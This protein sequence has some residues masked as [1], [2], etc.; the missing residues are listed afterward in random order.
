MNPGHPRSSTFRRGQPSAAAALVAAFAVGCLAPVP[1]PGPANSPAAS[2]TAASAQLVAPTISPTATPIPGPAE[3]SAAFDG[4]DGPD[5]TLEPADPA[6][7]R[8]TVDAN[9]IRVTV[10]IERNPMRAG[11][12]TWVTTTLTNTGRDT[13][14]W[15]TDGCSIHVGV[16]GEMPMHWSAGFVQAGAEKTFKDWAF[17]SEIPGPEQPIWLN[18]TPEPF[19]GQGDFGCADVGILHSL[20]TGRRIRDRHQWDGDAAPNQGPPP[21]GPAV[22]I[23]T[24]RSWWRG[25]A[26]LDLTNDAIIVRLPVQIVDGRDPRFLSAGQAVDVALTVP[27]FRRLLEAHPSIQDWEMPVIVQF[28]KAVP[29]WQVGFKTHDG[30][31]ILVDIDPLTAK[32]VRTAP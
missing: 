30:G 11:Q 4:P 10:E 15:I 7:R 21:S 23:G 5:A 24:F 31:S 20:E 1:P 26:D 9:G 32:V 22:L 12:A 18:L 27:A 19:V 3:R 28:K 14:R 8:A 16:R 29:A 2:R 17:T 13:L 6:L 25:P